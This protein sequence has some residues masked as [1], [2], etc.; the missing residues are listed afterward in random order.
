MFGAHE[1]RPPRGATHAKKRVGRGNASGHGTYAGRGLKGQRSR[2]GKK[3]AYDAFEGGQ[4]PTSRKFHVLRGFNNKWRVPFQPVNLEA[5]ERFAD[6]AEVTPETLK[7]AGILKHLREPVKILGRG[8]LTRKLTISAHAFS[9][10]AKER[11]EAAGG[12]AIVISDAAE[13]DS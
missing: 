10:T 7:Q 9:A 5:L 13:K 12:T 2:S 6:G 3:L 4:F 1:L 8:E 11:I